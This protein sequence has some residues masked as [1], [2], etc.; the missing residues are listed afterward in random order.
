ME[1]L[2]YAYIVKVL[3]NGFTISPVHEHIAHNGT[4][5][6]SCGLYDILK[7]YSISMELYGN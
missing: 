3:R 2:S 5:R 4:I 6:P 7:V 1:N